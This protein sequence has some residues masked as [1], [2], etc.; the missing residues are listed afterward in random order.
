MLDVVPVLMYEIKTKKKRHL[1]LGK[2]QT[3]DQTNGA[4]VRAC[5]CGQMCKRCP[6]KDVFYGERTKECHIN[7]LEPFN[8]H[9]ILP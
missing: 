7:V 9:G 6:E 4:C 5:V 2:Y 1:G 8:Y 3:G